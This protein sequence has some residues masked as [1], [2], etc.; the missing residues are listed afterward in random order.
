[1]SPVFDADQPKEHYVKFDPNGKG[2]SAEPLPPGSYPFDVMSADDTT[3]KSGNEMIALKLQVH[4]EDHS[5]YVNDWLL[6][7]VRN[8]L[9]HFCETT[10]LDHKYVAGE[11]VAA[12][13]VGKSGTVIIDIE[14]Q[15][16]FKP[17]NKVRDYE[18]KTE[19]Q[20]I[21]RKAAAAAATPDDDTVPF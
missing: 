10:G 2:T 11:L 1:M 19:A 8:R 7:K 18:G 13:C 4:G 14:E 5:V 21:P 17:K 12:D 6:E 15:P 3:S 9:V 16:G 20:V